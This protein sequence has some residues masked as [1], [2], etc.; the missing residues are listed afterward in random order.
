MTK[1]LGDRRA[2][3]LL[4][5]YY[6]TIQFAKDSGFNKEQLSAL[7]SIVKR[8]HEMAVG[9]RTSLSLLSRF[10]HTITDSRRLDLALSCGQP[11]C[12]A[13]LK[14]LAEIFSL[15]LL[16]TANAWLTAIARFLIVQMLHRTRSGSEKSGESS[17]VCEL[18]QSD[19]FISVPALI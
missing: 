14:L 15:V 11:M 16:P 17:V 5:L 1:A 12:I 6:Y 4:D 18:K 7:F 3:V 10:I 9:K 8:T 19:L 2:A 13:H